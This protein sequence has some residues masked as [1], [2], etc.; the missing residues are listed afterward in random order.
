M[1]SANAYGDCFAMHPHQTEVASLLFASHD[2]D[3]WAMRDQSLKRHTLAPSRCIP[4]D[5]LRHTILVI[6]QQDYEE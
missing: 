1:T 5:R 4:L 2:M 3:D 6:G